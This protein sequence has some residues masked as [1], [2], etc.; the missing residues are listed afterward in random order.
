MAILREVRHSRDLPI[1]L[2]LLGFPVPLLDA[3]S[4][5]L[6]GLRQSEDL[7]AVGG[8][9]N[10]FEETTRRS[11]MRVDL[12]VEH[13]ANRHPIAINIARNQ[14]LAIGRKRDVPR[15]FRQICAPPPGCRVPKNL[16]V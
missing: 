15:T 7:F 13:L 5:L 6:S 14:E 9:G 12:L 2:H 1:I 10:I 11:K 8:K 16:P 3:M 4:S